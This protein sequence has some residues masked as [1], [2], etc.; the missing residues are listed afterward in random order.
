M[1][2]TIGDPSAKG[3]WHTILRDYRLRARPPLF[4]LG[5][6]DLSVTVLSQQIRALNLAAAL[7]ESFSVPTLNESRKRLAI[8]G[9]GFAGLTLAAALLKK[10]AAVDITIFEERDTLL[11]LQ[12][13]SDSRWLHPKIYEW[14][15]DGSEANSAMLPVLNW[16]A[17]RASDVVVQILGEWGRV[18]R[19]AK[20]AGDALRLYCNTRHLQ[21][22][23][24]PNHPGRAQVEWVGERR[25]PADG[26][27][28]GEA[29]ATGQS[30]SF[31][32]VIM[33]VGFGL[34]KGDTVSYWRNETY[35]Q[36]SLT[37]ARATYMVSGQG[38]GAM[39][40]LLRLRISR[41]RQDRI[42]EELFQ[43]KTALLA[44]LR[45]LQ[46]EVENGSVG[47][48]LFE[49]FEALATS[50]GTSLEWEQ[51]E[52]HLRER[53][54]RDTDVVLHLRPEVRNLAALFSPRHRR[55]SFQNALLVYLLYRCGG[56]A[57]SFEAEEPLRLRFGIRKKHVVQRHGPDRLGQFTRI[58]A[59]EFSA[60]LRPEKLRQSANIHWQGGYFGFPGR[61]SQADDVGS[62][63]R[64]GWR[65]EYLP[66]PTSLAST[67]LVGAVA[68][69]L[70]QLRPRA[71]HDRLTLHRVIELNGETLLQQTC[72]YLGRADPPKQ[73]STG[74]TFPEDTATIGLALACRQPIRSLKGITPEHLQD[75]MDCLKLR[76]AAREMAPQVG[77]V[78]A[79][80]LLQPT[81]EYVGPSTVAG[82][83]YIDS[84]SSNYWLNDSEVEKICRVV[85][86]GLK[87][88]ESPFQ[89][90]ERLRNFQ[91]AEPRA[92]SDSALQLPDRVSFALE[93]VEGVQPPHTVG[94]FQF[95]YDV[96]DFAPPASSST[97]PI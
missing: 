51:L 18:V 24:C 68:G 56:F 59:P 17:G 91:L 46:K 94:P 31:D 41:Y 52:N 40:D 28:T 10:V 73:S 11:P 80:P 88:L 76:E 34:E 3:R 16:T 35:G 39:I 54:R 33:A 67:T 4:L 78:L 25:S 89:P 37:H 60:R 5:S 85:E 81:D 70:Q 38:D 92:G 12:Q 19:D 20:P 61:L 2:G 8:V 75:A 14:P 45:G 66:G 63:E 27:A 96:S 26:H 84:R 71:S 13:G 1:T 86:V 65:K 6:F 79:I 74:R 47:G 62:A 36:P 64:E 87:S 50:N 72:D 83:L 49:D 93:L 44:A 90:F 58:L 97:V 53:L 21:I 57:P 23:R 77:F 15:A 48:G 55:M 29:A 69:V 43:G 7:I 22:D 32:L 82:V 95:N 30:E 42:L 9:G